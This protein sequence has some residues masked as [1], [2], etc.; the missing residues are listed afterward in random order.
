VRIS[1]VARLAQALGLTPGQLVD[2]PGEA[3]QG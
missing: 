3:G 2:G 1:T